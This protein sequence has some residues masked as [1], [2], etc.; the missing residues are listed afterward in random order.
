MFATAA[1]GADDN[2]THIRC[3]GESNGFTSPLDSRVSADHLIDTVAGSD[4][5]KQPTQLL[6]KSLGTPARSGCHSIGRQILLVHEDHDARTNTRA[7][8]EW[9]RS[10]GTNS[11][12]AVCRRACYLECAT[13]PLKGLGRRAYAV[14][15]IRAFR[16]RG[17]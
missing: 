10:S 8:T 6:V 13:S 14:D 17:R 12:L 15:S 16:A 3:R 4:L 2:G 5:V 1:D 7:V 9:Y 11:R